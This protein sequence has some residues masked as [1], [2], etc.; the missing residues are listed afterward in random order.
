MAGKN[1]VSVFLILSVAVRL[2]SGN[3]VFA[4]NG[5]QSPPH[6]VNQ[7]TLKKYKVTVEYDETVQQQTAQLLIS[8]YKGSR[9]MLTGVNYLNISF[10]FVVSTYPPA[11]YYN[12]E[13]INNVDRLFTFCKVVGLATLAVGCLA[14][15]MIGKSVHHALQAL[16]FI[17]LVFVLQG[18]SVDGFTDWTQFI[19]N[20][21]KEASLVGGFTVVSCSDCSDER[22]LRYGYQPLFSE[23]ASIVFIIDMV[24][25][26]VLGIASFIAFMYRKHAIN[27]PC[28]TKFT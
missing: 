14:C 16:N 21:L 15:L 20:G 10:N 4:Y 11:I 13:A 22:A 19:V 25:L 24:G 23:N 28:L 2:N 18:Y 27:S 3:F 8:L 9:R 1:Q 5:K 26:G 6:A 17:V 12:P 7:I